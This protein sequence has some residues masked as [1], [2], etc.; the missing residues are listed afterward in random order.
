MDLKRILGSLVVLVIWGLSEYT[1]YYWGVLTLSNLGLLVGT[2][3]LSVAGVILGWVW[4]REDIV[5]WW[6]ARKDSHRS[7]P[8][9]PKDA[10]SNGEKAHQKEELDLLIKPLYLAFEKYPS[11]K[12]VDMLSYPAEMWKSVLV[13]GTFGDA[14][15]KE[16]P[17][18]EDTV[19]STINIMS[20][21]REL[22]QPKLQEA[23]DQFLAMRRDRREGRGQ[24]AV[25]WHPYF[26]DAAKVINEIAILV[27]ERYDLLTNK[28]K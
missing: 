24:Y 23:I 25:S 19:N 16:L 27:R 20:Q 21:H 14:K 18:A 8:E 10:L 17:G 28:N 13:S 6:K 11:S 7:S 26:D 3:L 4:R 22:A 1:L 2:A 15:N 12:L 9:K 5:R